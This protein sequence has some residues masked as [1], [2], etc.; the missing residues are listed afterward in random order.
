MA[1][2]QASRQAQSSASRDGQTLASDTLK[3]NRSGSSVTI[4]FFE[5]DGLHV[6]KLVYGPVVLDLALLIDNVH[7][8]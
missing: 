5:D 7:I 6:T 4:V 3:G 8:R 2:K 1:G